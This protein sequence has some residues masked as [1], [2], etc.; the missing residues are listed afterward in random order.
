MSLELNLARVPMVIAYRVSASSAAIVRALVRVKHVTLANLV[1]G[2]RP[3]IP[4]LMQE[5][6]TP[7]RLAEAVLG[8]LRSPEARAAQA[9]QGSEA[10]RLLGHGGPPP[11]VRAADILLDIAGIPRRHGGLGKDP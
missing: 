3:V 1:L 6:C 2:D 8:L 7:E 5:H 11:S 4:E 10:M 9:R